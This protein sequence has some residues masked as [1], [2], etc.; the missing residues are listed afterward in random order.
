[1]T[2]DKSKGT[3][4]KSTKNSRYTK[5]IVD[6]YAYYLYVN[7]IITTYPNKQAQE[8]VIF[9]NREYDR[10]KSYYNSARNE[11]RRLKL[12]KISKTKN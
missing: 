7:N 9:M 2:I 10:F 11:I 1:M 12:E 4:L 3:W 6:D 5:T 8:T